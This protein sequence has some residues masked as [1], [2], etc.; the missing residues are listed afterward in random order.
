MPRRKSTQQKINEGDLSKVGVNRLDTMLAAEP[1]AEN[2]LPLTSPRLKGDAQSIYTFFVQQLEQ[3]ELAKAPEMAALP[4]T[5]PEP[6]DFAVLK[7]QIL[8]FPERVAFG[9]RRGPEIGF[10]VACHPA[11]RRFCSTAQPT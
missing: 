11:V 3:S 9:I 7:W 2:G 8:R 4:E 6:I 5:L 10:R 1:R